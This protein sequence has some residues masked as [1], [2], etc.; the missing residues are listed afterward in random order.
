MGL[1]IAKLLR[2]AS[3]AAILC[4][5]LLSG[6]ADTL[7][8]GGFGDDNVPMVSSF[9]V[10]PVDGALLRGGERALFRLEIHG[11]L[12]QAYVPYGLA[13]DLDGAADS[14]PVWEASTRTSART[15]RL[16]P[17]DIPTTYTAIAR[18]SNNFGL[19][20]AGQTLT[21]T[22][23]PRET[24]AAQVSAADSAAGTADKESRP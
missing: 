10:Q 7:N 4:A 9:T 12:T 8:V 22:V 11:N 17:V 20:S 3:A 1:H 19:T 23:L 16:R 13:I 5:L 6:C 21:F 2:A 14:N 24:S 15:V 18:V